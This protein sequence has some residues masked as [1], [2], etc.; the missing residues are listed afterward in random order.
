MF[1][2]KAPPHMGYNLHGETITLVEKKIGY[3]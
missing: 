1:A 2:I 3:V